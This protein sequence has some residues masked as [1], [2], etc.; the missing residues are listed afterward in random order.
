MPHSQI[1][2][3]KTVPMKKIIIPFLC[4]ALLTGAASCAKSTKG[5]ISND[6]KVTAY[7]ATQSNY[8]SA[9]NNSKSH[10]VQ[11]GNV[12]VMT[13]SGVSN[14]MP[15][16][17]QVTSVTV[18]TFT[19]KIQK[20]GTWSSVQDISYSA[21]DHTLTENSGTWNFL[22]KSK[23]DDFKKN[24]R[25]MF[26]VLNQK[27]TQ[28]TAAGQNVNVSTFITGEKAL[29]YTVKESS[30]KKLVLERE[31]Q[32]VSKYGEQSNSSSLE[33]MITLEQ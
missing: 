25:V 13:Q 11:N 21:N 10:Q 28:N 17:E 8:N 27:I 31:H 24:E 33:E 15:D 1:T 6:W 19:Y 18:N 9:A 23:G 22:G 32:Y 3:L 5:K 2:M 30:G 20:D 29:I 26:N 14:G 16:P 4:A 12:L 7:E